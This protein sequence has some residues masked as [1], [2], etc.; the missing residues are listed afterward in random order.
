MRV[1]LPPLAICA[2]ALGLGVFAGLLLAVAGRPTLIPAFLSIAAF[3]L[4][5]TPAARG[6]VRSAQRSQGAVL[7]VGLVLIAGIAAGMR[8]GSD[9]LKSCARLIPDRSR[10]T[11]FGTL[12]DAVP[13]GMADDELVRVRV[14]AATVMEAIPA[15]EEQ[16][17]SDKAR[18]TACGLRSVT[19]Y[20]SPTGILIPAGKEVRLQGTWRQ[21]GKPGLLPRPEHRYGFL[22]RVS[23][24]TLGDQTTAPQRPGIATV[25]L[26]RW[27]SRLSMRLNRRLSPGHGPTGTALTL[28]DRSLLDRDVRDAFAKAGIVHL[29]AI[30]GMHVGLLSAGVVWL[31]GLVTRRLRRYVMAAAVMSVYILLIGAPPSAVRAGLMFW[32]YALSLNRGIRVGDL[33]GLAAV[34]AIVRD[35]MVVTDAGFQLSFAGFTGV[36]LG[37]RAKIPRRWPG[38]LRWV[39]QSVAVSVG[40]FLATAPVAATH[41]E[42]VAVSGI[43]ASVVAGGIVTLAL[44]SVLLAMALPWPLWIPFA[45]A[46][47]LLLA[48]LGAVANW[49]A[50]LPLGWEGPGIGVALWTVVAASL[51]LAVDRMA[52]RRGWGLLALAGAIA[53]VSAGPSVKALRARGTPM[54]CTLDVGQ[55]DAAAIRTAGGR[56]LLL[57]AGPRSAGD[58]VVDFLRR[59]GA[60]E[61]ELLSISHPHADHYGGAEAVLDAFRVQRVLD[62]GFAQPSTSYLE[63]LRRI[64]GEGAEWRRAHRGLSV[65]IDGV[66][67]TVLW[68]ASDNDLPGDANENSSVLLVEVAGFRYL[69]PGDA[70]AEVEE[71]VLSS[72]QNLQV[73]WLKLGHHGSN[74]SSS[75][76]WLEAADPELA[77]ASL[78]AGNSYGHPHAETLLRVDSTGVPALWRTDQDGTVCAEISRDGSWKLR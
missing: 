37:A 12:L 26:A 20:V 27:K 63:L 34:A 42:R 58:D 69:N 2:F 76:A 60:P 66:E 3:G 59:Q 38:V 23:A 19:A 28:A 44:P 68:P 16:N 7:A 31:M 32:G 74:T 10:V 67:I 17:K 9:A 36:V 41:F 5:L 55:G 78:G 54:V 39:T 48:A 14:A 52:A 50:T 73:D 65:D 25:A 40:A 71:A 46:S 13:A 15:Q 29:L 4:A 33:A 45:G 61:V 53:V 11:A 77:I 51:L 22:G 56:W 75:A 21:M 35:P 57:D 30:S 18:L 62:P 1:A 24:G 49:F 6:G 72:G 47:D 64:D 8:S 43:P 70:P